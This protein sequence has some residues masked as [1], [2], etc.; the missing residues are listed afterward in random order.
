MSDCE[1]CLMLEQKNE[2]K[3]IY[4]DPVCKAFLHEAP[5]NKG[6]AI[7]IPNNHYT[8]FEEVPDNELE[9][10]F[11]VANRVS[12]SVFE[13]LGA[14]GT[15]ILI[16]NGPSAGQDLNHF[17]INVIPRFENDGVNLDWE[18]KQADPNSLK[19]TKELISENADK[20]FY[21][22]DDKEPV[23]F[24]NKKLDNNESL[25]VKELRRIPQ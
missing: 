21:G 20:I 4:D 16:N 5:A 24:D 8:I 7:I 2:F 18:M 9:H 10:M 3:I 6:H 13:T 19:Q 22:N 1:I 15:N 23:S 14:H 17:I 12:V 25:M 11:I